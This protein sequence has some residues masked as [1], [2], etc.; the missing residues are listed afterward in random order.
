MSCTKDPYL[1]HVLYDELLHIV[2]TKNF[3]LIPAHG[4]HETSPSWSARST[5]SVR[6]TWSARS[7]WA[8][9]HSWSARSTSWSARRTPTPFMPCTQNPCTS[10]PDLLPRPCPAR[11]APGARTA[12]QLQ[13]S[14]ARTA[15]WSN[16]HRPRPATTCYF[17][18]WEQ[19]RDE[20]GGNG[21]DPSTLAEWGDVI[22]R[23]NQVCTTMGSLDL[24]NGTCMDVRTFRLLH[25]HKRIREPIMEEY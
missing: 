3:Y 10:W 15:H 25:N 7:T 12:H 21:V 18:S 13:P 17:H 1:I 9:A 6:I 11:S 20:D 14:G 4:P 19:W 24:N 16:W 8:A 5:W 22:S 23:P 2:R